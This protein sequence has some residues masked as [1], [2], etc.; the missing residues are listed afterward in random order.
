MEKNAKVVIIGGGV[1]RN[2]AQQAWPMLEM[3][4][5]TDRHGYDRT[6]RIFTDSPA[7]GGLSGCTVSESI[8]W[9]KYTEDAVTAAVQGALDVGG[10]VG[11]GH[12]DNRK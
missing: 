3:S 4:G 8:S 11:A 7:W 5:K 6:V 1:P 9:G 2:W 12:T 10:A